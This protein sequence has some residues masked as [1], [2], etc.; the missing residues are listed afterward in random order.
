M[1]YSAFTY[2]T[3]FKVGSG[4]YEL[5]GLAPYGLP[6]FADLILDELVTVHDDGSLRLD[7]RHFGDSHGAR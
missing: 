5:M 2:Y 7:M 6:R 3:G 1:L 4:E